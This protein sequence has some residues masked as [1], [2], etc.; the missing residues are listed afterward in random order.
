MLDNFLK[1]W[2]PVIGFKNKERIVYYINLYLHWEKRERLDIGLDSLQELTE[3]SA[4]DKVYAS[5]AS[6]YLG[7]IFL[8]YQTY[9][10][11]VSPGLIK[12]LMVCYLFLDFCLDSP[13]SSEFSKEYMTKVT[14]IIGEDVVRLKQGVPLDPE[15]ENYHY[16]FKAYRRIVKARPKILN[17]LLNLFALEV[18]SSQV[19][20]NPNA[21]EEDLLEICRLK[22]EETVMAI[23]ILLGIDSSE[24]EQL[25]LIGHC[26]QL[27]DDL[28]DI[29][30]DIED[31]INTIVTQTLR[32]E[33]VLDS[34]YQKLFGLLEKIAPRYFLVRYGFA[35]VALNTITRPKYC[36]IEL[37]KRVDRY[38][39]LDYRYGANLLEWAAL[40]LTR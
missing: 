31:G 18:K 29:E 33:G 8:S 5:A 13:D 4:P 20:K 12:D 30:F 38:V 14:E 17:S 22:G 36:S 26:C 9:G 3:L 11:I 37:K 27:V 25:R 39:Y 40:L 21:T 24:E 2:F 6:C 15:K 28:L 10:K 19:Q 23:G 34:L 35:M 1:K 32:N 7:C 16:S